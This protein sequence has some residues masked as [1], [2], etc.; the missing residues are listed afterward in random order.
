MPRDVITSSPSVNTMAAAQLAAKRSEW[1]ART[2]RFYAYVATTASMFCSRQ[3]ANLS[4]CFI[5]PSLLS[6]S[7]TSGI[8]ESPPLEVPTVDWAR[9]SLH[10]AADTFQNCPFQL[11][12]WAEAP[13]SVRVSPGAN[14]PCC[15]A[16][17]QPWYSLSTS[18]GLEGDIDGLRLPARLGAVD[19][20]IHLFGPETRLRQLSLRHSGG[21][22][23][24]IPSR[25]IGIG[26]SLSEYTM[27]CCMIDHRA[28]AAV[29]QDVQ[30][31]IGSPRR[32]TQ[33]RLQMQC[34]RGASPSRRCTL[35]CGAA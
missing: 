24:E 28:H 33:Q 29:R 19:S 1:L 21:E 20:P 8:A 17:L 22:A 10:R 26:C 5:F 12:S 23:V 31:A 7:K 2:V 32:S 9:I 27:H 14:C 35:P 4:V 15:R 13:C 16:R 18:L 25:S 11:L 30:V 6:C 3:R 34:A